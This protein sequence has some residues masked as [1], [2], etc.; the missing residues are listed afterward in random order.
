[1]SCGMWL[2]ILLLLLLVVVSVTQ[3]PTW[4]VR[5]FAGSNA[6]MS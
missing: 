6:A 2:A 5:G 1:M 4:N 3:Q